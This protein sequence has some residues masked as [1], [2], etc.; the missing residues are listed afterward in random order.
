MKRYIQKT[1]ELPQ[2]DNESGGSVANVHNLLISIIKII[3][4]IMSK[5]VT[6]SVIAECD[7][8]IKL[9]LSMVDIFDTALSNI[10]RRA[11]IW[12]RK[13]NCVS[14]LSLP[15]Q[16]RIYGSLRQHYEG[17]YCGKTIIQ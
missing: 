15:Q 16:M 11:K 10:N 4:L 12:V 6:E 3:P 7:D 9:F 17:S 14:L 5:E 1:S 8:A 13:K 2:K